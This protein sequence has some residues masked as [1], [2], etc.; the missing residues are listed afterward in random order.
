MNHLAFKVRRHPR[1][2]ANDRFLRQADIHREAED[3]RFGSRLC[4]NVG[5][6]RILID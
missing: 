1:T 3:F 6:V 4:E 5:W 2:E